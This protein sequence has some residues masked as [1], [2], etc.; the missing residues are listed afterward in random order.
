MAQASTDSG[1]FEMDA[2]TDAEKAYHE[3]ASIATV[4]LLIKPEEVRPARGL[5]RECA[6]GDF[7]YIWEED[8]IPQAC[9]YCGGEFVAQQVLEQYPAWLQGFRSDVRRALDFFSNV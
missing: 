8:E 2:Q 5:M 7:Q 4:L 9:P 1:E 6:N 3:G